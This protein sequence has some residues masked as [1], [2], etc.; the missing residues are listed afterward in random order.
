[1]V[2]SSHQFLSG[3]E[4]AI[5]RGASAKTLKNRKKQA[6]R[7]QTILQLKIAGRTLEDIGRRFGITKERV[8][9]IVIRAES[10]RP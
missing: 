1:M 9:Q 6:A 8:R 3:G 7:R 4:M 2:K 10:E 5:A